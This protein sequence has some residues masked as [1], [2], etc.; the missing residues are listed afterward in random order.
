VTRSWEFGPAE[1]THEDRKLYFYAISCAFSVLVRHAGE[2]GRG[3]CHFADGE[4]IIAAEV[5]L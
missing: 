1:F 5:R 4:V 3:W 2:Q